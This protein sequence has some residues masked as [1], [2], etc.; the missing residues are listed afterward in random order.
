MQ[1]YYKI[2]KRNCSKQNSTMTPMIS[3][4]G[5]TIMIMSYY[6]AKVIVADAIKV[7]FGWA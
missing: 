6:M 2:G 5:V 7:L 1:V 4:P 3:N